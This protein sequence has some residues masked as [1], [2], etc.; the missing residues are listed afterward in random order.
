M[1]FKFIKLV[2]RIQTSEDHFFFLLNKQ[3]FL[4]I[5]AKYFRFSFFDL[6]VKTLFLYLNRLLVG[7]RG[8]LVPL[9]IVIVLILSSVFSTISVTNAHVTRGP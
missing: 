3:V 5:K 7:Y 9:A 4:L 2:Y 6:G 1:S 8:Y